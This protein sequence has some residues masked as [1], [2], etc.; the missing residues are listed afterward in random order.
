MA[1]SRARATWSKNFIYEILHYGTIP[2]RESHLLISR[3]PQ[4]PF[5][6]R[7]VLGVY[8]QT[9]DIAWLRSTVPAIAQVLPLLDYRAARGG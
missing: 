6:T 9:G 7:M 3:G 1:R 4:P 2:E 5:L 8:E